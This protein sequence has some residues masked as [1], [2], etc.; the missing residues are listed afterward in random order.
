MTA[1]QEIN[2]IEFLLGDGIYIEKREDIEKELDPEDAYWEKGC[3]LDYILYTNDGVTMES[4][5]LL[6]L[7]RIGQE[8]L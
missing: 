5:S 8:S 7:I 3:T 1:Q 6:E 2:G 4:D